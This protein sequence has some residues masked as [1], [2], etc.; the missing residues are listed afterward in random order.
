MIGGFVTLISL[1]LT[2]SLIQDYG[3]VH[4][5]LPV[6]GATVTTPILLT[7]P[8]HGFPTPQ[9]GQPPNLAIHGIVSGVT[10]TTEANG[11]WVLTP[12]DPNTLALTTLSAQGLPQN[13]VGVDAYTGGGQ[14]QYALPD[15]GILLGRRNER[16]NSAVA[17]PRVLFIPTDGRAWTFESYG[18]AGPDLQPASVPNARGSA[19][20]QAMTLQPQLATQLLT[21]EVYVNGCGEDYGDAISP[22]Y[23]DFDATQAIV[24]CLY[25]Q[26]FDAV[27]G[28][29]RA[30][31]LRESWPSQRDTAASV[32][33]RG[34]QWV[35]L[36]EIQ[37]PVTK[38]P[39][40]FVPT[41]TYMQ[42]T[43]E[44]ANPGTNDPIVIDVY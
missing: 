42:L 10:G 36:I 34:Q 29:P 31:V 28:L 32:V 38:P 18:G 12:V 4:A 23:Y 44:P 30:K 2:A 27:G 26:L 7:S 13:S 1:N 24:F 39:K 20:Q 19:Q 33:Q 16:L 22:N 15:G 11:L 8:N 35:G 9:N 3:V 14:I 41:G 5:T 25:A 37:M 21:F 43:V 40:Q 17:T 6:T